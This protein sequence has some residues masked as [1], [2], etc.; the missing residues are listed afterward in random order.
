MIMRK[1][2]TMANVIWCADTSE[3]TV[4]PVNVNIPLPMNMW[5]EEGQLTGKFIYRESRSQAAIDLCE[6]IDDEVVRLMEIK[7]NLQGS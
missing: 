7:N 5:R 4:L 6:A 2:L 3:Y 1:G